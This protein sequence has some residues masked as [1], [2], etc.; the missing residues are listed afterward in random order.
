MKKCFF[1]LIALLCVSIS[2]CANQNAAPISLSSSSLVSNESSQTNND[3]ES[4]YSNETAK[5]ETIEAMIQKY[6]YPSHNGPSWADAKNDGINLYFTDGTITHVPIS[7]SGPGLRQKHAI[8][9]WDDAA[10]IVYDPEDNSNTISIISTR[11]KGQSWQSS[12]LEVEDAQKYSHFYLSF[13][14][15]ENG[16]LILREREGSNSLIYSTVN[17][18][19]TWSLPVQFFAPDAIYSIS[20]VDDFYCIAGENKLYPVL[21]KS[22][23]GIDWNETTLPLDYSEYTGGY[24]VYTD[25]SSNKGL[26]VVVGISDIKDPTLQYFSSNDNGQSWSLYKAG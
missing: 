23:D 5:D 17:M 10:V 8:S 2:A 14:N 9:I 6:E 15:V 21:I 3:S 12:N 18:G 26:A 22:V 25:F 13:Q 24:C 4:K 1:V 7:S 20:A 11:D 16:I 19:R